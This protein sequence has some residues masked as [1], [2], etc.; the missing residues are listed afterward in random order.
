MTNLQYNIVL[1][2][3]KEGGFTV[4]VP[5]LPGCVTYGKN[6]KEAKGMAEDAIRAYVASL[7]K[8]NESVP[9]DEES[10][11]AS[12]QFATSKMNKKMIYA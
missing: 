6:L 8:H 1:K 5:S 3:E 2:P 9:S 7:I 10:F 11:I 4:I 12:L